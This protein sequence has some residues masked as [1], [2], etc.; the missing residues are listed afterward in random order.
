MLRG[1]DFAALSVAALGRFFYFLRRF[2]C[3]TGNANIISLQKAWG[4]AVQIRMLFALVVQAVEML[5]KLLLFRKKFSRL[6]W[7]RFMGKSA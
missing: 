1:F 6:D 4:E 3:Y 2:A 7:L 5:K